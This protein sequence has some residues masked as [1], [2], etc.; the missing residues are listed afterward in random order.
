MIGFAAF[1][2]L[3]S[4][5]ILLPLRLLTRVRQAVDKRQSTPEYS[6]NAA[7]VQSCNTNTAKPVKEFHV[8]QARQKTSAKRIRSAVIALQA[9]RRSGGRHD[10]FR[11]RRR[12][13]SG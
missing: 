11:G 6:S 5:G 2:L 1:K 9:C 10:G 12:R 7:A 8:S 13:F 4:I 3:I